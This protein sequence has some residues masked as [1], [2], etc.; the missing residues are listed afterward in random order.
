MVLVEIPGDTI[1]V[2]GGRLLVLVNAYR[3]ATYMKEILKA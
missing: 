1:G 2:R 3:L